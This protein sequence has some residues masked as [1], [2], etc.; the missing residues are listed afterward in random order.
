MDNPILVKKRWKKSNLP[1]V[2]Y[3]ITF[4]ENT[5]LILKEQKIIANKGNS[6][7]QSKNGLVSMSDRITKGIIE[8]FGNV[9]FEFDAV[10]L[11]RKNKL[12]TP[13]DYGI[14]EDDINKY[15]ELPFFENEWVISKE[16]KF[17]V[18]D[19]N[20]VFLITSRDFQ[21]SIFDEVTKLLRSKGI[22]H[23]FLSVRWLH[24][25]ILSDIPRY[26]YRIEN[27]SKFNEEAKHV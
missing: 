26:F 8:F 11:Y 9:V 22:R 18:N 7:C 21:E 24:D 10:S 15:D 25:N 4:V 14:S 19:I 23:S 12:I 2:F 16:L 27:W 17:D 5:P 6:I 3:H 13:R 20:K 1:M